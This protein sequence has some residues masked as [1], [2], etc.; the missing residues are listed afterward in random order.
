MTPPIVVDIDGTITR[1]DGSSAVDP[2]AFEELRGWPAPVVIATGKAF[3]YPVALCQFVG[4]PTLVIAENG[5]IVLAGDEIRITGDASAPREV[6]R[7]YREAGYDLGWGE[8]DLVNRWRETEVAVNRASPLAPLE[9]LAEDHGLEVVDT[10]YAYHVKD[11]AITKGEGLRAVCRALGRPV[12]QFV[13]IGDSEN[14]VSTFS[15][16]GRSFAVANADEAALAA[17]DEVTA[18]GYSSGAL[19]VLSELR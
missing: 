15:V 8:S 14:D 5:G 10:G 1:G 2:R 4:I 11:P 9:A 18:E 12:E 16:V 7:E 17:A 3:P 13:A 6:A 19:S